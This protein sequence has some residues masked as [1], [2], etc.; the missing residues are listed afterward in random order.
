MEIKFTLNGKKVQTE[1]APDLLLLRPSAENGLLQCEAGMRDSQLWFVYGNGMDK[2]RYCPCK[3][4]W[5]GP[6]RPDRE[7]RDP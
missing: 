3:L 5:R 2:K 4:C 7:D 1:A 6:R